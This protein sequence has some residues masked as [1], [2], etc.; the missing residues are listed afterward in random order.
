MGERLRDDVDLQA[1]R[2]GAALWPENTLA[3]FAGALAVG[4]T[5][6]ECDVHVSLDGIPMVVHDRRLGP[7]KYADTSP[8]ADPDPFYP[9]VGGLVTDLSLAQLKTVD[10]GSRVP[11]AFPGRLPA[12]AARIPTLDELFALVADRGADGV[13]FNIETKFDALAP[14]E[15]APRERF[16]EVVVEHVRRAG[17]VDRVSVQCFDWACLRLVREA[18]PGIRLNVLAAPKYLRAG[19]PEASP[20]LGGVH[21]DDYP[22]LA[23]AVSAQGFESISPAHGYPFASGVED[24]AY[25]PFTTSALVEAAHAAGLTVVPY[26]VDDP[27]T[28]RR[29]LDLGVDGL[30]TNYPGR[31]RELLAERGERLPPA[32]PGPAQG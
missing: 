18:E 22:D 9:Y 31:L 2:G 20:W 26:T 30:V 21:I 6:L 7:E 28:M 29:L 16:A 11:A 25:R 4:V 1:H 17:L 24:P 8:A 10:A 19:K 27:A 15:S 13:R 23:S 14:N 32:Y 3:A 12:P 5:T